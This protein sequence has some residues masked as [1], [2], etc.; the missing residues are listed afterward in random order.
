MPLL[1]AS[2]VPLPVQAEEMPKIHADASAELTYPEITSDYLILE[3]LDTGQILWS[4]NPD[5]QMYPASM[6]KMMTEIIAIEAF[7]DTSQTIEITADMLAGLAEANATVAGFAIGDTPTVLDCL[8]GAALPSGADAV[9]AL[10]VAVS[11]SIPAFVDQMN[12]KAAELGM[13][14]THFANPTGLFDE[15]HYSSVSDIAL[16][17]KYCLQSQVFQ[18]LISTRQY[19]TTPLASHPAGISL[20]STFW[21]HIN[22][23][24]GSYSIPGFI[25]AKTGYTTNAGSCLASTASENGMNLM[26]VSAHSMV[27]LGHI[28]DAETVYAW[29]ASAF[30]QKTILTAGDTLLE[31]SLLDTMPKQSV[32]FTAAQ[33]VT[34]DLPQQAELTVSDTVPDPI[35]TPVK[36]GN[37]LG[38][39][40]ISLQGQVLYSQDLTAPESAARNPLAYVIRITTAFVKAHPFLT[41]FYA[42]SAVFLVL[43]ICR[44]AV[45]SRRRA[46]RARRRRN[47]EKRRRSMQRHDSQ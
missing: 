40:T 9:N 31:R 22:N 4:V 26:L 33:T 7:S 3:D 11:G 28:R 41:V 16:L 24:D 5:A 25:G 6:T 46:R 20:S 44:F 12:A 18:G 8:Y 38:T 23:G 21:P 14:H 34:L 29:A 2:T 42:A 27:S 39:Y 43:L 17:M 35:E 10:A 32:T 19:T 37:V 1:L 36:Q 45:L 13:T 30:E 47:A 15:N